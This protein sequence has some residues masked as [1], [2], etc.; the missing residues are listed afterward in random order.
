MLDFANL[1]RTTRY[2]LHTHTPF[3]DGRAP[4]RDFVEAAVAIGF[5]CIGFTPHSPIPFKSTCNMAEADVARYLGEIASLRREFGDRIAIYSSMEID[6]TGTWG[7][8][9]GYFLGLPLDYRLGSV[10][11]LP[12]LTVSDQMVDVD[13]RYEN[14]AKKMHTYFDDDIEWVVRTYFARMTRMVEAGG[15]DI[16]GHCDKI[17]LNASQFRD[18]IDREPWFEALVLDLID[19]V[20]DHHLQIEVNTKAWER[21]HRFFPNQRYFSHLKRIG[22][23]LVFNSDAHQPDLLDAGRQ[24]AIDQWLKA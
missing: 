21:H 17:S 8:A 2:N 23:P 18:G 13:G 3:C 9:D 19:C 14:F 22:A 7:P 4:M 1:T 5:A 15:L 20:M 10:H 11:F 16:V 12:A 24:E 6:Y